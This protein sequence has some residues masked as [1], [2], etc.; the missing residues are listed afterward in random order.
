[1]LRHLACRRAV[2]LSSSGALARRAS[3]RAAPILGTQSR[4]FLSSQIEVPIPELGAESIVEGGILQL[5]KKPGDFVAAEE[6]VAE[7]ETDKVTIEAKSPQAGTIAAFHVDVGETVEVGGKFFTLT[8]GGE[9]PPPSPTADAAAAPAGRPAAP[10][11][12]AASP[13]A[14]APSLAF[15]GA[16]RVHPSGKPSLIRFPPRG[17]AAIAAAKVA[18][19]SAPAVAAKAPPRPVAVAPRAGTI[20][21]DDLPERFKR[22]IISEEEMLAV[23]TGGADFTF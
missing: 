11:A 19:A 3:A 4:R 10:A 7:I 17:A 22:P 23:E 6:A 20:S 2:A 5:M 9:A 18:A 15:S 16:G 1:M 21:Y 14:A 12:P 13:A 8:L